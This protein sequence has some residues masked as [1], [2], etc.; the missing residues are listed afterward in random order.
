MVVLD[1]DAVRWVVWL[2]VVV[3]SVGAVSIVLEWDWD[4]VWCCGGVL[5]ATIDRW[6]GV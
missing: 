6:W 2:N 4:M 5:Q 3:M 1:I